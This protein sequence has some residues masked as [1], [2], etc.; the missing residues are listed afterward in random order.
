MH[1]LGKGGVHRNEFSPEGGEL[2]QE[3]TVCRHPTS[4]RRRPER[5]GG[6]EIFYIRRPDFEGRGGSSDSRMRTQ[7]KWTCSMRK[8]F[9]FLK[10][11]GGKPR[12]GGGERASA[13]RSLLERG[14][15]KKGILVVPEGKKKKRMPNSQGKEH[16]CFAP[17]G[18]GGERQ[19]EKKNWKK[20]DLCQSRG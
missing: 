8:G 14:G 6:K 7:G 15:E 2:T 10:G 12:E 5:G 16:R 13:R 18:R 17:A 3:G 9:R 19:S 1:F 20:E 11:Q 4:Q